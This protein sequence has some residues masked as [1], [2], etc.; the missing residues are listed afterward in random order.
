MKCLYFLSDPLYT[1]A[2]VFS[3]ATVS[4]VILAFKTAYSDELCWGGEK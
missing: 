1:T 4:A 2:S 3:L